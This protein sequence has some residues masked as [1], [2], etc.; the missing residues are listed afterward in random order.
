[1]SYDIDIRSNDSYSEYVDKSSV[2]SFVLGLQGF[3]LT[4]DQI[5]YKNSLLNLYI[6]IDLESVDNLGELIHLDSSEAKDKHE[7]NINCVRLHIPYAYMYGDERDQ[8]YFDISC[9]IA[10][11][12]GWQ[13]YDYQQ[14]TYLNLNR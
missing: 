6:D 4:E 8:R 3:Y 10:N 11:Y 13:A 5:Y 12:L 14:G 2:T 1:M 9:E 7:T